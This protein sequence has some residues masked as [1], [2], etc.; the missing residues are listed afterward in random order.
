MNNEKEGKIMK[1]YENPML[2]V[3]EVA[4]A[5]IV[6]TSITLPERNDPNETPATPL[7]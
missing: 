5:D 2:N 7:G 1:K 6:R 4:E 3:I